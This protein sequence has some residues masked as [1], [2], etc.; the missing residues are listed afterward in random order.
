MAEQIPAPPWRKQR[1]PA[2]AKPQLSQDVIIDAALRILDAEGL[3]A[4]SMRR[5]AEELGT[6]AASLYAHVSNKDELLELIYERV[7]GEI[8]IPEPD[9]KRWQEQLRELALASMRVLSE[10]NDIAQASLA[11]LPIGPNALRLGEGMLSI[12]LAG[13][14]PPQAAAWAVDRISL[15]IAADAYEGSLY[16]I[17]QRSSGKDFDTWA[18]EYFGQMRTYYASLP[19]AL[20]PSFTK[21]LDAM[22]SGGSEERFEF[23]LDMMIRSLASYA[24]QPEAAPPHRDELRPSG[25][26]A[27]AP[28]LSG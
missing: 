12:I 3:A 21:H 27:A 8:E 9:P 1:R 18:E 6:G 22:M 23:G 20:F 24:V 11:N 26:P 28:K 14:V 2:S 16:L 4:V 25:K 15:Y 10:H 17:K 13:G 5:V 7:L 19:P